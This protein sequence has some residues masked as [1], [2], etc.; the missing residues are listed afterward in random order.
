[1]NVPN[2]SFV[3]PELVPFLNTIVRYNAQTKKYESYSLTSNEW[4]GHPDTCNE[5]LGM[6]D[7]VR[8]YQNQPDSWGQTFTFDN[9]VL[10]YLC[11]YIDRGIADRFPEHV[12]SLTDERVLNEYRETM[13]NTDLVVAFINER[14]NSCSEEDM[15]EEKSIQLL[16]VQKDKREYQCR[17]L[18]KNCISVS[19]GVELL[20]AMKKKRIEKIY[21]DNLKKYVSQN[22]VESWI[23]Q[24]AP[25]IILFQSDKKDDCLKCQCAETQLAK[26][27]WTPDK[28]DML[29]EE[30]LKIS[31]NESK[32]RWKIGGIAATIGAFATLFTQIYLI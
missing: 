17:R 23:R 31:L 28:I 32:T 18:A 19:K 27:G 13:Y 20:F 9:S 5:G 24:R 14:K 25:G 30:W 3:K 10:S 22:D 26:L 7:I 15:I 1:M 4:L 29:L 11:H 6:A 2:G 21:C 16:K 8:A 12:V